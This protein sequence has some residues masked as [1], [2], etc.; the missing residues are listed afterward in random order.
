M[1]LGVDIGGTKTLVGI[2]DEHGRITE[3]TKFPTP[4]KYEEFLE[5]LRQNLAQFG[6]ITFKAAGI[7][8]P[9]RLDRESGVAISCGNL[10]WKNKPILK[11]VSKVAGCP[12]V[13]ENDAKLAGLSEAML[14]KGEFSRVLYI[15]ISTGIGTALI[16]NQQIDINFGDTGGAGIMLEHE[17]KTGPWESFA[18]GKAIVKR[19]GK[20]AHDIYDDKTWQLIANDIAVGLIEV[21]AMT[22]PDVVIVGGGVGTHLTRFVKPLTEALK[23]Y[24]NTMLPIP[25]IRQ[26]ER[27]ETAVVYGCYD[28]AKATYRP[29]HDLRV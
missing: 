7:G 9:G 25:P 23:R 28:L 10:G 2:L 20:K 26:A 12:A 18:S 6:D 11:D 16:V 19:F 13:F 15:T 4:G 27:P 5:E 8:V 29:Q 22:E 17:G 21:I 24:E 14:V 1:Y 3:I